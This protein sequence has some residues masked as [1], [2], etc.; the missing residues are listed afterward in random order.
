MG[1]KQDWRAY[2]DEI[3]NFV[4]H[5]GPM[6]ENIDLKATVCHFRF[7]QI[8]DLANNIGVRTDDDK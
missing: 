5:S 6:N 4:L 3:R 8:V 7:N 2:L 1:R